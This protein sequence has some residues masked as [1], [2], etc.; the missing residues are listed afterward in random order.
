MSI[1]LTNKKP[2]SSQLEMIDPQANKLFSKTATNDLLGVSN[3][4]SSFNNNPE[5]QI[6]VANLLDSQTSSPTM[7][8]DVCDNVASFGNS[9]IGSVGNSSNQRKGTLNAVAKEP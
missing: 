9:K 4:M 8:Q 6:M 2:D 7:K 1:D 3:G 5:G